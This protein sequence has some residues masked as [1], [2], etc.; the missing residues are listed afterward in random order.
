MDLKKLALDAAKKEAEKAVLNKVAN[1]V[2]GDPH[3]PRRSLMAKLMNVKGKLTI[4]VA[5]IAGLI[6]AVAELM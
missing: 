4:A 2:I 6:A 1:G 5:A 3:P